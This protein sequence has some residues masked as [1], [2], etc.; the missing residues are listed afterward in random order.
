MDHRLP[1]QFQLDGPGTAII[2]FGQDPSDIDPDPY[3]QIHI[4]IIGSSP[5]ETTLRFLDNG[6]N[7][8]PDQ[9]VAINIVSAAG[10]KG[11]D[12]GDAGLFRGSI[13]IHGSVADPIQLAGLADG[14]SIH[15]QNLPGTPVQ[16][17]SNAA[18]GDNVSIV[19]SNDIAALD[20]AGGWV[21]GSLLAESL[22]EAQISGDFAADV[23]LQQD[24]G[25]F[26]VFGG[27]LSSASFQTGLAAGDGDG[28]AA[29]ITATAVDG[30]GGSITGNYTLDGNVGQFVASGGSFDGSLVADEAGLIQATLDPSTATGGDL[31]GNIQLDSF[32]DISSLG[33]TVSAT[34]TTMDATAFHGQVA[35]MMLNGLGGRINSPNSFH[36]A[37]DVAAI[38]GHDIHLRIDSLAE[39]HSIRAISDAFGNPPTLRGDFTARR[40][41][42]IIVDENGTADFELTTTGESWQLEE[43]AAWARIEAPQGSWLSHIQIQPGTLPGELIID[44]A[45]F[46]FD[47]AQG[48]LLGDNRRL[49][50]IRQGFQT[51]FHVIPASWHNHLNPFD[52]NADGIVSPIDVLLIINHLNSSGSG[53]LLQPSVL[54]AVPAPFLDPSDDDFVSPLDALFVINHL[55]SNSMAGE[56]EATTPW[57]TDRYFATL[58]LAKSEEWSARDDKCLP[59]RNLDSGS[60]VGSSLLRLGDDEAGYGSFHQ[61]P[62]QFFDVPLKER[63]PD[64]ADQHDAVILELL[65]EHRTVSKGVLP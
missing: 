46:D 20:I 59:P 36:F 26:E 7:P 56:G 21:G 62:P 51:E 40:F 22:M 47:S 65:G 13:D 6:D 57:Y 25:C 61:H 28:D 49:E 54:R 24:L 43:Q 2:R 30:V 44:G 53:P 50:A 10:L 18:F 31:A 8:A 27:N 52:V 17:L 48:M 42:T 16:I 45:R 12:F 64:E 32:E 29:C 19:V 55:N 35:A 23:A 37:G 9:L 34:V 33:G 58:D 63:S 5:T 4:E 14:S 1:G 41:G 38:I 3:D 15:I 11:I 60:R 39:V